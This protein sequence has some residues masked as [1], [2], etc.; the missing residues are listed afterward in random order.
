MKINLTNPDLYFSAL[1]GM[2]DAKILNFQTDF[3]KKIISIL[4]DNM[5]AAFLGMETYLGEK[6]IS[7]ELQGAT[8]LYFS[9]DFSNEDTYR[10]FDFEINKKTS[11]KNYELLLSLSPSGKISCDFK[12]IIISEQQ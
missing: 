7:I 10:I 3:Q 2:H 6:E 11:S 12:L 8:K 1:G 9:C 5:N 4:I